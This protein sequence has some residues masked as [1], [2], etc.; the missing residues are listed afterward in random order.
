ML[1]IETLLQHA[2]LDQAFQTRGEHVAGDAEMLLQLVEAVG[3]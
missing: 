3:I 2:V 1:L